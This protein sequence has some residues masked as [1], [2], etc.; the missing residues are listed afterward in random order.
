MKGGRRQPRDPRQFLRERL[1]GEI[2]AAKD[3]AA[4]DLAAL[5]G[6][7]VPTGDVVDVGDIEGGIHIARHPAVQE[8]EHEA[9]GRGWA[10]VPGPDGKVG[11]TMVTGR[12]W[13]AARSTSCSATYLDRLYEPKRWPTSA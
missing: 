3:V 6:E 11:S 9:P 5:E 1:E 2:L 10:P 12:P 8:V 7:D 4:P 13:A